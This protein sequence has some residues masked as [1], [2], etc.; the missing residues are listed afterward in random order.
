MKQRTVIARSSVLMGFAALLGLQATFSRFS[1]DSQLAGREP[2]SPVQAGRH[3]KNATALA[4]PPP[5][6]RQLTGSWIGNT[7][8]PPLPWRLYSPF[9]MRERYRDQKILFAGDS[10]AR[11]AAMTLFPILNAS[12]PNAEL[13]EVDYLAILNL[14]RGTITEK[15]TKYTRGMHVRICRDVTEQEESVMVDSNS[16]TTTNITDTESPQKLSSQHH[17][18]EVLL[19]WVPCF[20]EVTN[21]VER[22][23]RG[24]TH[25]TDSMDIFVISASTHEYHNFFKNGCYKGKTE[26]PITDTF[27]TD[28][29]APSIYE[30]LL[31]LLHALAELQRSKPHL[32]IIWKTGGFLVKDDSN[33]HKERINRHINEMAMDFIDNLQ[34]K[35]PLQPT[36]NSTQQQQPHRSNREEEDEDATRIHQN[37]NNQVQYIHW[38]GA[39]EPR[40]FGPARIHGDTEAHYGLEARL[41][42]LQMLTNVLVASAAP[43][44]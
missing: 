43:A 21:F 26:W 34:Q 37:H 6:L 8:V 36:N 38:G 41:V 30:S 17:G 22:E 16:N 12:S 5:P 31:S 15:C 1:I 28:K 4:S 14:N 23:V 7:W 40:S 2:C 25:L 9:E 3:N 13:E 20:A 27:Y 11:R 44:Q 29:L 32:H 35:H 39:M 10:S 33:G 42:F 18:G 24:E 19:M